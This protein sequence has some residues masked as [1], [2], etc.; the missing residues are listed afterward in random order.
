[1]TTSRA[2]TITA[3]VLQVLLALMVAG[4]GAAKL[5]G[6]PAM[7][8][9]FDH[10][11]VGQWFRF[12]VGAVELAGGVGLLVPRVRALAALGLLVL[13]LCATAVNLAVLRVS[14]IASLMLGAVALVIVLLRRHELP[15]KIQALAPS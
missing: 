7:I 4:G 9:M 12:V 11:G 6:D 2:T 5:F 8:E 1:V 10:I 14:P 13:L 15:S 3:W